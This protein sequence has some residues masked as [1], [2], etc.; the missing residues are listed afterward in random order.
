[1]SLIVLRFGLVGCQRPAQ[2]PTREALDGG[3]GSVTISLGSDDC[4]GVSF[5]ATP[6]EARIGQPISV[7]ASGTDV[8]SD[9]GNAITYAWT[10]SNGYFQDPTAASTTYVCPGRD[11]AGPQT[12]TISASDSNCVTS[13]S[14][15]I[16]CIALADGGGPATVGPPAGADAGVN[17]AHGDPTMCEGDPCNQCT[18][19][20]CDTLTSAPAHGTV[21][22][23]GCDI[24]VSDDDIARC[25][26]LYACMRDSGCVANSD[27][28]KCWCGSVDPYEC[29]TGMTPPGG[30]CV[31]EFNDA[32]GSGDATVINDRLTDSKYPLGGAINLAA[33]RSASCSR[34]SDPPNPV[35]S[36]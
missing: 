36:L 11:H 19:A 4:P 20:N 21:P 27:P 8:D 3:F 23:A 34:L 10:A 35:C 32:A 14:A 15:T 9:A 7:A 2:Y 30:P 1:M 29:E 12:I 22:I 31:K 18:N 24:F 17:C 16:L 28:T 25:Q 13:R 26:R 5:T 6:A 33:C